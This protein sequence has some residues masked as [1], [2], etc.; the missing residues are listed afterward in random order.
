MLVLTN[1]MTTLRSVCFLHV[2]AQCIPPLIRFD[3]TPLVALQRRNWSVTPDGH[4]IFSR[5]HSS[6]HA[7]RIIHPWAIEQTLRLHQRIHQRREAASYI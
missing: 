6:R 5:A 7:T 3:W 1:D 2:H 4:R